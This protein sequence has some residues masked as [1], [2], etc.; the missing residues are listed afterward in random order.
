ML[1]PG[2]VLVIDLFGNIAY[3]ALAGNNLVA[4]ILGAS[5][6]GFVIDGAIRIWTAC[7]N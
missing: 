2:D 1:R 7:S 5:R 4:A 3:G 6:N